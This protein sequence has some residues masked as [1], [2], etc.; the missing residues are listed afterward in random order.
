M[1]VFPV[2]QM[3]NHVVITTILMIKYERIRKGNFFSNVALVLR[4][5]GT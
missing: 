5:L 4:F 1:D 2:Q 3:L